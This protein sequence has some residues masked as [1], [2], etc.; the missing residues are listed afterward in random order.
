AEPTARRFPSASEIYSETLKATV[1][2]QKLSANGEVAETHSGF[3]LESGMLITAFEAIDGATRL[4]LVLADGR[5][6]ESDRVVAWNRWQDWAILHVDSDRLPHLDPA[7]VASWDVGDRCYFLDVASEGNRVIVDENV[8]GKNDFPRAGPRVNVSFPS[9][10][11]AIG[12]PLLNEYGDVIGMV[13]GALIPGAT[14]LDTL[15]LSFT[16]VPSAGAT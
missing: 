11:Q 16:G 1:F 13:G 12:S 3:F 9:A 5:R 7:K 2:V 15:E 10:K 14:S 8:T 6:L 4:R